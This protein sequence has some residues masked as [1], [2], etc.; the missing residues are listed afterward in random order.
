M[1][2]LPSNFHCVIKKQNQT[3]QLKQPTNQQPPPA[4]T[5]HNHSKG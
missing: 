5:K 3:V 2:K 1:Y 4:P